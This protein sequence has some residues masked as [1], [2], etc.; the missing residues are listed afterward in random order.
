MFSPDREPHPAVS[1]IKFLQQP[2]SFHS[3]NDSDCD[4]VVTVIVK[5]DRSATIALRG[6]NRYT[7]IDLAHITFSWQLISNRSVK[8][9]QS[10]SFFLE[11]RNGVY[12]AILVIGSAVQ[13]ILKLERS[14]PG[15]CCKYFLNIVGRLKSNRS[16]AKSG[17][18]LVRQQFKV[19]FHF[20]ESISAS[21][22]EVP[23]NTRA[24]TK[25]AMTS[26]DDEV[27]VYFRDQESTST[28]D[29]P[30]ITI[31]KAT[32]SLATYSPTGRNLF[33]GV[34]R[35]NFTR[36]ATDNDKGGLESILDFILPSI[37]QS[38][39]DLIGLVRGY[40]EFSHHSH[41]RRVGLLE[42]SPPRVVCSGIQVDRT[43]EGRSIRIAADCTVVPCHGGSALFKVSLK[44]TIFS[45]ARVCISCKVVPQP[46]LRKV[47]SLPR[48][49]LNLQ[50]DASLYHIRYFGRGPDENYPDR[51]AA[52]EIGVHSTT[53]SK[54]AYLKYI[55]PGENGSRSDCEWISFEDSAGDGLLIVS[56]KEGES[57]ASFSCSAQ[58][59]S[60]LELELATHTCDL[61][62]RQDGKSPIHTNIDS[63]LMG[64]GGDNR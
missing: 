39:Y 12:E 41:W 7:F 56:K 33:A 8:S 53:P 63:K 50:L 4:S 21:R 49:G 44:Y 61:E 16:W 35:P 25:L 55:V 22:A 13:S 42:A 28:T 59:H 40:E 31:D 58:L 14:S 62:P 38:L 1:E 19:V 37:H 10:G 54:M 30:I 64:V 47:L 26:D 17:H 48:I 2:V 27:R 18:V 11:N 34:A 15:A 3:S 46:A 32:G 51:K 43:E 29:T 52:A 36:A 45:D 24:G 9:I 57:A 20:E 6:S 23:S 5:S 60:N